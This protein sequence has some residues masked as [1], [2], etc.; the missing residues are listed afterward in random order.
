VLE[1]DP[2]DTPPLWLRAVLAAACA[3]LCALMLVQVLPRGLSTHAIIAVGGLL[4]AGVFI[5]T[6]NTGVK[7]AL[8]M[9]FYIAVLG[10]MV[11]FLP[12]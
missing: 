1:Y 6:A 11:F 4:A 5:V 10:F 2:Y 3:V 8:G 12:V 9:I 7:A